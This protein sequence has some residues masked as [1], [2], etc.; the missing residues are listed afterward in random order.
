MVGRVFVQFSGLLVGNDLPFLQ[1]DGPFRIGKHI[2]GIVAGREH[3]YSFFFQIGEQFSTQCIALEIIDMA[4]GF[5]QQENFGFLCQYPGEGHP[6]LLSATELLHLGLGKSLHFDEGQKLIVFKNKLKEESNVTVTLNL[7]AGEGDEG[8]V[9]E[10][11]VG[12]GGDKVSDSESDDDDDDDDV[13]AAAAMLDSGAGNVDNDPSA[14]TKKRA[15]AEEEAGSEGDD[16]AA[17]AKKRAKTDAQV[18]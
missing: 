4:K 18:E 5:V 14:G 6:L 7:G 17:P 1:N 10:G 8:S 12:G 11:S 2:V 16:S 13:M 3:R 9:V 15:A